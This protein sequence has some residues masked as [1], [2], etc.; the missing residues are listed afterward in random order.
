MAMLGRKLLFLT[1]LVVILLSA[2]VRSVSAVT[3]PTFPSC[4]NPQ[5]T[6]KVSYFQGTHG[7]VGNSSNFTG[8]DSVY[9][10][11]GDTLLQCLCADNGQGVQTNWWK[12]SSLTQDQINILV[13]Q[14]WILVPDG[15]AWGLESAPYLAQNSSFSC[16]GQQGGGSNGGGPGDGLSDGRSDGRGG[17]ALGAS[18]GNVLGLASTGNVLFILSMIVTGIL[19][20]G[21]G[22]IFDKKKKQVPAK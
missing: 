17:T 10:V 15:S 11:S 16:P 14:G 8:R 13:S 2:N 22:I 5:G 12:V 3:T 9:S 6:Q 1:V 21:A 18:I 4:I 19:L 7:V 20:I